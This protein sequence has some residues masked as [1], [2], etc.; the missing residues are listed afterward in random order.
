MTVED[1]NFT[2]E[3]DKSSETAQ[4]FI[5]NVLKSKVLS[6]KMLDF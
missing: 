5:R 1:E 6:K 2:I 3:P 4:L